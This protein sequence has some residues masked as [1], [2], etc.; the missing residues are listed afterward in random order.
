[1]SPRTLQRK[2]EAEGTSFRGLVDEE[3]R[4]RAE[5]LRARGTLL[6]EAALRLG[7]SDSSGLTRARRRWSS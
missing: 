4:L 6:K 7:Y 1:M 3:R 2:L 5:Q